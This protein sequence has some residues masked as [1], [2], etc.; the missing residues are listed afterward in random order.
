MPNATSDKEQAP[1]KP[2]VLFTMKFE[3]WTDGEITRDLVEKVQ[4]ERGAPKAWR[5]E[6]RDFALSV[7]KTVGDKTHLFESLLAALDIPVD[8]MKK[9]YSLDKSTQAK[10]DKLSSAIAGATESS[11]SSETESDEFNFDKEE[12]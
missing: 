12:K 1:E 10:V 4:G 11:S 6:P 7:K 5:L 3:I 2:K 9:A 8:E